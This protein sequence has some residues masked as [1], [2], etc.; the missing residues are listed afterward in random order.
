MADADL[1]L[2]P[3]VLVLLE[4]PAAPAVVAEHLEDSLAM[5]AEVIFAERSQR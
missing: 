1:V 4:E 3:V 2:A 5:P